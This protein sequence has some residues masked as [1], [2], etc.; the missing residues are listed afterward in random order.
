MQLKVSMSDPTWPRRTA[1]SCIDRAIT[2]N[3]PTQH[4]KAEITVARWQAGNGQYTPW[5][6]VDC[7]LLPAGQIYCH[8]DC[9]A[10]LIDFSI[11]KRR[12][13]SKVA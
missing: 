5:T 7:S 1:D 6:V 3:C 10:Q 13:C 2:V 4:L 9:L 8:V 11:L 12:K